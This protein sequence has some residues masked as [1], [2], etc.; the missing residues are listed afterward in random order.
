MTQPELRSLVQGLPFAVRELP[1][2]HHLHLDDEAGA[3][4]VAS[5]FNAFFQA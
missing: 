3:E 5:L 1:G 4:A 2:G